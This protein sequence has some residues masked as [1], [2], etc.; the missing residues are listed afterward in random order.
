MKYHLFFLN[1]NNKYW[2]ARRDKKEELF[3]I[4]C[5]FFII[6][7]IAM[8]RGEKEKATMYFVCS[9]MIGSRL[10]LY[11]YG[12]L[13]THSTIIL[14]LLLRECALDSDIPTKG[15]RTG[16]SGLKFDISERKAD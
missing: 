8:L 7:K 13:I 4:N 10:T 1:N 12:P 3:R 11:Y 9:F 14:I 16:Y 6:I 15:L 2:S 5:H